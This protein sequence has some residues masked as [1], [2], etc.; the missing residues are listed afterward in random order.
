MRMSLG[1][2]QKSLCFHQWI[3]KK[4]GMKVSCAPD[5]TSPVATMIYDRQRP[6]ATSLY[7]EWD[8]CRCR[9]LELMR[10]QIGD[11]PG[12]TA[13]VGVWRGDFAR[14]INHCFPDRKL[15]LYDTYAGYDERDLSYDENAGNIDA[16][17]SEIWAHAKQ[18]VPDLL[19]EEIMQKMSHPEQC[20][21]RPGYFPETI[22]A[23]EEKELFVFISLDVNL[24]QP[25]YAGL[26]FFYP[27]L[28][29]GGGNLFA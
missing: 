9:S 3:A 4:A 26:E 29:E 11:I 20:I 19:I 5:W 23:E 18:E 22:T 8:Y 16:S 21:F 17:F 7:G 13:E 28:Q 15:F 6:P 10:E 27:R 25:T 2:F 14:L 1:L 12:S 24:Y